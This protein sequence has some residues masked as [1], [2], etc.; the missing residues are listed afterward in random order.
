MV[1]YSNTITW[2]NV[3]MCSYFVL[4]YARTVTNKHHTLTYKEVN[5]KAWC[6]WSTH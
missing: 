1:M 4:S 5:K 6:L 3:Q 2:E